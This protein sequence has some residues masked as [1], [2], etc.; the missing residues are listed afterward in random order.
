VVDYD[1][2]GKP[3]ILIEGQNWSKG[4]TGWLDPSFNAFKLNSKNKFE[5]VLIK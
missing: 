4:P 2:D 3:E 1:L 5:R